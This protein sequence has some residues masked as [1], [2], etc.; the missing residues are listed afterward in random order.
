MSSVVGVASTTRP[1]TSNVEALAPAASTDMIATAK[2]PHLL[3][4]QVRPEAAT[5]PRCSGYGFV[6]CRPEV[7]GFFTEPSESDSSE[8]RLTKPDGSA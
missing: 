6:G 4:D 7:H 2:R 8:E 5:P 3:L 1:V